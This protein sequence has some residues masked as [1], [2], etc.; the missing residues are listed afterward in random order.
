MQPAFAEAVRVSERVL[1]HQLRSLMEERSDLERLMRLGIAALAGTLAGAGL[2][3]QSSIP[4]DAGPVVL[5]GLGILVQTLA[6]ALAS[7]ATSR[8]EASVGPDIKDLYQALGRGPARID[9]LRMALLDQAAFSQRHNVRSLQRAVR[10][11]RIA[12]NLLFAG[13]GLAFVG[14]AYVVGGAILA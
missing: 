3:V 14:F 2:L 10:R 12:S 7:G 5:V 6:A 13:A 11:R 9:D 1:D 4:V 8:S